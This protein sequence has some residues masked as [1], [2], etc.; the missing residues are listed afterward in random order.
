LLEGRRTRATPAD[1]LAG[2]TLDL[3]QQQHLRDTGSRADRPGQNEIV[4]I[5]ACADRRRSGGH[6]SPL[7]RRTAKHLIEPGEGNAVP[8]GERRHAARLTVDVSDRGRSVE[9]RRPRSQRLEDGVCGTEWSMLDVEI[10]AGCDALRIGCAA[11]DRP[12]GTV[13]PDPDSRAPVR[14]KQS[15]RSQQA[16]S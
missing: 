12:V 13:G 15:V 6:A 7:R 14:V 3:L 5:G 11:G 4:A 10:A 8:A 2:Q 9:R 1:A 16:P